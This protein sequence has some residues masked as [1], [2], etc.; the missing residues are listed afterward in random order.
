MLAMFCFALRR[1]VFERVGKLDESFGLGLLEDD[2]YSERIRQA[3]YR[4]AYADDVLVHHFGEASF[5]TLF[6]TGERD[7][8]LRANSR[9]FEEKWGVP[10]EGHEQGRSDEY[11]R[12]VER[13][14]LE[15]GGAVPEGAR[16]LVVSRGD[17]QLLD[18][19]RPSAHFPQGEG[20]IY[21]GYYPADS[22]EAIDQL[23]RAREQGAEYLL[24]PQTSLW[25][26]DYYDDFAEHL[27]TRYSEMKLDGA[28]LV[29]GLDASRGAH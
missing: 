13:I 23:E 18:L 5:G 28:C 19:G 21:A 9:R 15:V 10:W 11:G 29:F 14:R 20:G 2:D 3:G 17:E 22:R 8:L 4:L 12:L 16:M 7:A 27:R 25:W 24:F 1:D 26:L 6:A